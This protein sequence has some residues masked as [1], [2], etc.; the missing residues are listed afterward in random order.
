MAALDFKIIKK[1]HLIKAPFL[2]EEWNFF[3]VASFF[4]ETN[5][6]K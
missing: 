1:P 6:F 5:L 4:K 3:W 2:K